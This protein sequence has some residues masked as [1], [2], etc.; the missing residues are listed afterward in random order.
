[1][2]SVGHAQT[3]LLKFSTLEWKKSSP[4][5]SY[6]E[7]YSFAAF[8]YGNE[9]YIVGGRTKNE[10]L[11]KVTSFDPMTEKWTP[12]GNLKS[13][14]Y[15]H[16]IEVISDKLYVIGGLETFEY[17]DLLTGFACSVLTDASFEHKDY[18]TLYGFY[19]SKCE[20]GSLNFS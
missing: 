10:I 6:T 7:I 12:I 16:T 18:P 13:P 14:R 9:F 5:L 3:E 15:D 1:M 4:Y 2:G 17:C 11:S 8:F 19:P 20:L